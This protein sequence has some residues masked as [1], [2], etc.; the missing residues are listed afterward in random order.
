MPTIPTIPPPRIP[1]VPHV[2]PPSAGG[3][4]NNGPC[5]NLDKK[6]SDS[7]ETHKL[8][9]AYKFDAD[10]MIY[11]TY[12]TGY[13]PGGVNRRNEPGFGPYNPDFLDNYEIGWKTTWFERTL[14]WNGAVF[15]E[16]WDNFQFGFLGP[17]G[18]TIIKNAPGGATIPGVETD[19]EWAAT[20]NLTLSASAMWIDPSSMAISAR[21]VPTA[22]AIRFRF[23]NAQRTLTSPEISR[24]TA[25]R[26]RSRRNS[27][28]T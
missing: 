4:L 12:S 16:K 21:R 17:N 11:A 26:F 18:L 14:R 27:R 2:P 23:S 8:N 28:A 6:V 7:D 3:G 15:Y 19:L 22:T 25:P 24:P 1:A 10:H 20:D 13:R 9:L 5:T